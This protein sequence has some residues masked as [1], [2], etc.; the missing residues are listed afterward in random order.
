MALKGYVERRQLTNYLLQCFQIVVDALNEADDDEDEDEAISRRLGRGFAAAM[1]PS[2]VMADI[3][4][5]RAEGSST[6]S[7]KPYGTFDERKRGA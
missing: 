7:S 1:T 3:R 5:A 6:H 2:V 4:H